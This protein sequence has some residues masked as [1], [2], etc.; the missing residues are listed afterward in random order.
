M[1]LTTRVAKAGEI[2]EDNK[3]FDANTLRMFAAEQPDKY[4]YL[5]GPQELWLKKEKEKKPNAH[6]G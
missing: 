3:V 1:P 5:P 6:I 2:R 4:E